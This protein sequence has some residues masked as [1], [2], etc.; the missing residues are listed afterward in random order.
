MAELS[1]SSGISTEPLLG[2]TI[3]EHFKRIATANPDALALVDRKSNRRWTYAEF[4]ADTDALAVGLLE[5]GVKKGDRV[6]IW[7]QNVAEWAL[8]QYATAKMGAILVNVNPAYRSHELEYVAK[9][10]G[11][12]L[13]ISQVVAP[14]HS[15][16]HAIGTE[17]AAK[18]PALDLVFLDTVPED[19]IGGANIGERQ[20]FA[21]L[22][23]HG[24]QLLAD[25]G[26][27]YGVRLQQ[28]MDDLSADEPIN[29]QYTSGTTGFPKGV[30]LSH[31]NILNNGFF[32]G[33]TLSYTTADTVVV[34]VPYYSRA[35]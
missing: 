25:S 35:P 1:Y 32:I 15:D 31:H 26:A 16:F 12:T 23:G 17:V 3:G 21:R 11:M 13:L 2:I 9:Q 8:V 22:I 19:L 20:S 24:R 28:V 4:D 29:I 33:E 14:P 34:P 6:G 7:A 5:R 27:K 30:T 18:V 10:S